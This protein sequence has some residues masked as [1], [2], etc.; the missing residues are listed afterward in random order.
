M[1]YKGTN[2]A[3]IGTGVMGSGMCMNLIKAGINAN[4]YNRTK[5]KAENLVS[6]GATW[7]DTIASAV[8][9][10]D[11]VFTMVGYP[12]DVEEIYFEKN[13][14]LNSV[15]EGKII[16][17]CT[18]SSPDLAKRI[19]EA[20]KKVG[21][22]ALDAPVSGG[23]T[24]ARDASLT[25]MVGGDKTAFERV[26]PFFELMGKTIILQGGA[27]SGQH[28]KMANQIAIAGSL[29]GAVESVIYAE[30][31]GLD[32][33]LVLKSI[34]SGSAGSWQLQNMVPRMLK[35][36]F[37]PG[38]YAKHFLKDLRIAINSAKASGLQLPMLSLAEGFFSKMCESEYSNLGTH[39]LYKFYKS[40]KFL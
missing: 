9:N 14:I 35:K 37:N 3:F 19:Y 18:T 11:I 27:G 39:A 25:I 16:V 7:H 6:N 1:N 10:T 12:S 38:F 17:D 28:T 20:A 32:P 4:I 2:I 33:D 34:S 22:F 30:Q 26:K 23:D 40:G 24:G 21:I 31:N 8:S 36:D 15:K 13:G 5:S 29:F